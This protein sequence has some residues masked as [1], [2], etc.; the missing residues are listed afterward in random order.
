MKKLHVREFKK[1]L[2]ILGA[3]SLITVPGLV[4]AQ[5]AN[6]EDTTPSVV[7]DEIQTETTNPYPLPTEPANESDI[8]LATETIET[9]DTEDQVVPNDPETE[10]VQDG[11]NLGEAQLIAQAE[12][13]E[14]TII[15][16]KIKTVDGNAVYAFYFEDGWKVYVQAIDGR[17]VRVF[18]ASDKKHDCENK[19]M[20]NSEF[21]TWL[22]SR[23]EQRR[24]NREAAPAAQVANQ[25]PERRQD[26]RSFKN[27]SDTNR[28]E[29]N[30]RS[31][32]N[33]HHRRNHR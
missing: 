1:H 25:M 26:R 17:V 21:K 27:R 33:N 29:N 15:N 32:N 30:S 8:D 9:P 19:K 18:D 22:Q 20:K 23:K 24:A 12:H 4:Y 13:S 10:V 28:N 16:T 6:N 2:M 11:V 3:V 7:S 14:S 31:R 5:N